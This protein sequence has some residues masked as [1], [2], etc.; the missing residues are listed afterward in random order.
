MNKDFEI[1]PTAVLKTTDKY[2]R[3]KDVFFASFKKLYQ[4]WTE[5]QL[6]FPLEETNEWLNKQFVENMGQFCM[7]NEDVT[8]FLSYSVDDKIDIVNISQFVA[9]KEYQEPML[10]YLRK[11]FPTETFY[12]VIR[13]YNFKGIDFFLQKGCSIVANRSPNYSSEFYYGILMPPPSS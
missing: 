4:G 1:V 2:A 11:I 10:A 8:S 6:G 13:K 3:L 9:N 7:L 5:E 12:G